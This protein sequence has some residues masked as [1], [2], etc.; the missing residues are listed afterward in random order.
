MNKLFIIVLIIMIGCF[1]NKPLFAL[2][3][4]FYDSP[5]P[6]AMGSAFV[7]VADDIND[8]FYNPAGLAVLQHD[9]KIEVLGM[10]ARHSI[11]EERYGI[12]GARGLV[13]N[14]LLGGIF[15]NFGFGVVEQQNRELIELDPP[16]FG[17]MPLDAKYVTYI[18]GFG[19]EINDKLSFGL[20]F[21]MF[22]CSPSYKNNGKTYRKN[23]QWFNGDVGLLLKPRKN[24]FFGIV[25][26][27]ISVIS[28]TWAEQKPILKIGTAYQGA[29]DKLL[30]TTDVSEKADSPSLDISFG[31]E[32]KLLD[33]L[34]LR[35]GYKQ[36]QDSQTMSGGL[37]VKPFENFWLDYVYQNNESLTSKHLVSVGG[38][39]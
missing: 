34:F 20:N 16:L 14:P 6:M 26:K 33:W 4:F 23:E 5:R 2:E 25:V 17:A 38:R 30:L 37:G 7:S 9:D 13:K 12:L 29:G 10:L 27:N 35:S 24:L 21:K 22:D 3:R 32:I 15:P 39:I 19:K 1:L 18:L 28:N 31:A 11:E 8:I 36:S